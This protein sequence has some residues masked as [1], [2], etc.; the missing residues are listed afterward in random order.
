MDSDYRCYSLAGVK[1]RL[2]GKQLVLVLFVTASLTCDYQGTLG[3]GRM[4][5]SCPVLVWY[6]YMV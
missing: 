6:V 5:L 2:L 1:T 3:L 4:V